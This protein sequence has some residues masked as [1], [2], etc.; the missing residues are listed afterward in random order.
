[1]ADF[2]A[3]RAQ[4]EAAKSLLNRSRNILANIRNGDWRERPDETSSAQLFAVADRSRGD[5]TTAE[6]DMAT[7]VVQESAEGSIVEELADLYDDGR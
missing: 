7:S 6:S 1:M 2:G 3:C 4:T 5:V